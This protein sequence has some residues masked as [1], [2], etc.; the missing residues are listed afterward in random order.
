MPW[1]TR[2]L[3]TLIPVLVCAPLCVISGLGYYDAPDLLDEHAWL[4]DHMICWSVAL[5]T[6]ILIRIPDNTFSHRAAQ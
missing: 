3:L 5:P 4:F 1:Y 2:M 6:V